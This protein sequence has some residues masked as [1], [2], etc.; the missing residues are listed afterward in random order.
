MISNNSEDSELDT[1]PKNC[2]LNKINLNYA[3]KT[4]KKNAMEL[5]TPNSHSNAI[6]KIIR[7]R[8][9]M[10]ESP[11]RNL[12][13]FSRNSKLETFQ[14]S[15]PKDNFKIDSHFIQNTIPNDFKLIDA[16]ETTI[17]GSN[18]MEEDQK[19]MVLLKS[20]VMGDDETSSKKVKRS[21]T[22]PTKPNIFVRKLNF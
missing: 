12:E 8:F 15:P 6:V 5:T 21:P 7:H 17:T 11:N 20:D 22:V 16:L 18:T 14:A 4:V 19:P 2:K 13:T 9:S 3:W 1:F 10:A